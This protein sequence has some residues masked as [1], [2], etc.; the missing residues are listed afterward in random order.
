MGTM[1]SIPDVEEFAAYRV[2]KKEEEPR[3]RSL[4][5]WIRSKAREGSI[6][7]WRKKWAEENSGT[8][9]RKLVPDPVKWANEGRELGFFVIQ[10]LTGHGVFNT[11]R[12]RIG[13]AASDKC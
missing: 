4:K 5:K 2:N 1:D 11:Y 10:V 6:D 8:W 3:T 7:K 12:H 13:K 9:T